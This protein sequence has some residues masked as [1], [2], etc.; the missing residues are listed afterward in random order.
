MRRRTPLLILV[1]L[2]GVAAASALHAQE[3]QYDV[4]S[5]DP[6][7]GASIPKAK[8][9]KRAQQTAAPAGGPVAAKPAR[10]GGDRQFGELEGWSPGKAPPKP[11][12]DGSS[13]A[14]GRGPVSVSPTGNLGVGLPF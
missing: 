4:Q 13:A 7:G 9:G 14:P 5:L 3:L 2:A 8:K 6:K 11:K 1:M 10:P 12:E